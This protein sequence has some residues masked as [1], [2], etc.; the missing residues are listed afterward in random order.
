MRTAS[1]TGVLWASALQ[2]IAQRL[3]SLVGRRGDDAHDGAIELWDQDALR[4]R[5]RIVRGVV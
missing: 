4:V 3:Q 2:A 1:S 5:H